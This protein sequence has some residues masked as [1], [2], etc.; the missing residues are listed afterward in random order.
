MEVVINISI[1]LFLFQWM[2]GAANISL[3]EQRMAGDSMAEL[4][5][6]SLY[7]SQG[8]R[9]LELITKCI[10]PFDTQ[11]MDREARF[12]L[13]P[14]WCSS[15]I[16]RNKTAQFNLRCGLFPSFS[17]SFRPKFIWIGPTAPALQLLLTGA[18]WLLFDSELPILAFPL[19]SSLYYIILTSCL[20]Y[21]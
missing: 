1:K 11:R 13:P 2:N 15:L 14:C 8:K 10:M 4:T 5:L 9:G 20:Q 18:T 19:E 12:D 3:L 21:Y 6:N 17:L 7:I 16:P